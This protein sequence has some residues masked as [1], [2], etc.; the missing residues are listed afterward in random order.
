MQIQKI[1][2]KPAIIIS[3]ISVLSFLCLSFYTSCKTKKLLKKYEI[4]YQITE[5]NF[6]TFE[7]AINESWSKIILSDHSTLVPEYCYTYNQREIDSLNTQY[8][9]NKIL[10]IIPELSCNTC[11]DDVYDIL[12]YAEDSLGISIPILTAKNRYREII[13]ILLDYS[14][15][16][17]LYYVRTDWFFSENDEIEYAPYFVFM[18]QYKICYH[19]FIPQPNHPHITKRYLTNIKQRYES[20]LLNSKSTFSSN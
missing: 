13:N 18:N 19:F 17:D 11:Y 16:T 9:T 6:N 2:K 5:S 3:V 14:L 7:N 1:M 10:L 15:R 4:A 20:M 8:F 12:H